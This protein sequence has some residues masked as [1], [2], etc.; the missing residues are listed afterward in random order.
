M[1]TDQECPSECSHKFHEPG[2]S[3]SM[4]V[5]PTPESDFFKNLFPEVFKSKVL[6]DEGFVKPIVPCTLNFDEERTDSI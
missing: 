4:K 6:L 3:K 5:E 2:I 1:T